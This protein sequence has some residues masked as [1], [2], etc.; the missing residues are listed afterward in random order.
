MSMFRAA[1]AAVSALVLSAAALGAAPARAADYQ[2]NVN[3]ALTESDPIFQGLMDFEKG[4][5]TRSGG[6]IDVRLYSGSQLGKD[7]D[8]LEQARAGANVAVIVDG[9]RL[10]EFVPQFGILGAPYVADGFPDLRILAN[11]DLFHEWEEDLAK[12][13]NHRVLSFNWFQGQRHMLTSKDVRTPADLDGVRIRTPGAPVWMETVRAMGATPTPMGWTEV[14]PALQQQVI[15][16]AEAQH[17]ATYGAKL[18]EVIDHITLTGHIN[19]IT[20]IVA[21]ETWWQSLPDDLKTIVR[22]EAI[23]AGD[24]ASEATIASLANYEEMMRKEGVTIDAIDTTP[25]KV[26]TEGVYEK[27]GYADL[28]KKVDAVI[29]KGKAS[30]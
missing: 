11:S 30:Q 19:L 21:S 24:A 23:R 4:V 20:G 10:A 29:A 22:E 17:P 2:L 15:D 7:E 3:S 25:F 28:K 16:G 27:L 1:A 9:G 26:A 12:T 5:E 18:Y 6:R 13:S 14:Y 8:V